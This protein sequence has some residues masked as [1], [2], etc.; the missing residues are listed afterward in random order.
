MDTQMEPLN[1]ADATELKSCCAA[2]YQSDWARLLLGES[3]HPGGMALTERLSVLLELGPG[4]RVLDVAAGQGAS[5]LFLARRFGCEV[6]GVDYG[7]ESVRKANAAAEAAGVAHLVRFQQGD[8]ERLPVEDGSFDAVICECAFCT[9]P[10][11]RAAAAEFARV[12]R[13]GG[14]VGLSDLT[15]AGVVPPELHGLLAWIACIA[16]AQPLERYVQ[17]LADAGLRVDLTEQ[18]DAALSSLV[19]DIRARLLGAELLVKLK[20]ID[21]PTV[22]FEQAKTLARAAADAVK[23]GRFG[24]AVVTAVKEVSARG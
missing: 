11:K 4:K 6:I 24:Y 20:K 5:A 18:H 14:R 13:P 15:R 3:F 8:A 21:L 10:D 1:P 12:L 9:F 17:Y 23:A 16:D 2:L 19:Q 22:D 7:S